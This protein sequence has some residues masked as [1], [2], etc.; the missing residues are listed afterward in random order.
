LVGYINAKGEKKPCKDL[1]QI[2]GVT[3]FK[4]LL[5][6][7]RQVQVDMRFNTAY[8]WYRSLKKMIQVVKDRN[9]KEAVK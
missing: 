9:Y 8:Y 2:Y 6:K 1:Y 3:F 5:E 4:G 7:V